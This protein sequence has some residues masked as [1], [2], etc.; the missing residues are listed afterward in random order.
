MN[1]E[2]DVANGRDVGNIISDFNNATRKIRE[3]VKFQP[4]IPEDV[5]EQLAKDILNSQIN[6]DG[7]ASEEDE[8]KLKRTKGAKDNGIWGTMTINTDVDSEA[9]GDAGHAWILFISADG[10]TKK[11]LSL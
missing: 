6:G 5:L 8:R 1:P 7:E 2:D 11:T 4:W 10:K 9:D 3:E